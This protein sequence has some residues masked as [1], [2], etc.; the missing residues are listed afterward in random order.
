MSYFVKIDS[1]VDRPASGIKMR[2]QAEGFGFLTSERNA[3]K[4]AL[5][6]SLGY[7]LTGNQVHPLV[8][9]RLGNFVNIVHD[10]SFFPVGTGE[11]FACRIYVRNDLL[12]NQQDQPLSLFQIKGSRSF[13][14]HFSGEMYEAGL[15]LDFMK[16]I[17]ARDPKNFK[18]N[19]I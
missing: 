14:V 11:K 15:H 19:K 2:V 4:T 1:F 16:A 10:D 12:D 5:R 3:A 17:L 8:R 7:M 18:Q 6:D 13:L 9:M